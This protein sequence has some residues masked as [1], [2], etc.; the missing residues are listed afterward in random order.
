[1]FLYHT[2]STQ[3]D[4]IRGLCFCHRLKKEILNIFIRSQLSLALVILW[5]L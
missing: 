5:T 4:R 1:M 3:H 2:L